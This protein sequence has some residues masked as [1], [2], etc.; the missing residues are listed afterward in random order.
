MMLMVQALQHVLL[1]WDQDALPSLPQRVIRDKVIIVLFQALFRTLRLQNANGSWG[2]TNSSEESA[3]AVIL[4][5]CLADLPCAQ[6]LW[7][8]V[9]C[10]I[11][12]GRSFIVQTKHDTA[13]SEYLWIEKV[14]YGSD[15]LRQAYIFAA[16]KDNVSGT[17][18]VMGK[19][20]SM[21]D[22]PTEKISKFMS[23]YSK[24]PM[25][26]DMPSWFVRGALVEGYLLL[27]QL[28]EVR[29][30]VF[31]RQGMAEDRY[32]EYIPFTWAA[33]NGIDKSYLGTDFIYQ[34]NVISFLNYQIDEYMEAVIGE[35]F[36][37]RLN[38]IRIIIDEIFHRWNTG[39]NG[40]ISNKAEEVDG[41]RGI[42]STKM[43]AEAIGSSHPNQSTTVAEDITKRFIIEV[44]G[45]PGKIS[46]VEGVD[47]QMDFERP[48][49]LSTNTS[50][51]IA[52]SETYETSASSVSSSSSSPLTLESVNV[53]LSSFVSHILSHT[54]IR[55][56]SSASLQD[57]AL[58]LRTFL[59]AHLT[60]IETSRRLYLSPSKSSRLN[61]ASTP[62]MAF[63]T[64][65]RSI[66]ADHTSCSYSFA[67]A[68]CLL[69]SSCNQTEGKSLD[70]FPTATSRYLAKATAQHL[71]S[72]CRMYNDFG[73][74][75]RDRAERNLNSVDFPE[76]KDHE[77]GSDG[78][79]GDAELKAR[80]M[81]LAEL[82]REFL[83]CAKR[84]LEREVDTI[85]G[86]H[87]NSN[88]DLAKRFV[89]CF[90]RITDCYGQIY[91]VK[92]IASR[93]K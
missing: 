56:A 35:Q 76:L 60:Q 44:Y 43:N 1:L 89:D 70:L 2:G 72:L 33:A 37:D 19:A 46:T 16:L 83:S 55:Y 53:T 63:F 61:H 84:R 18:A 26:Q 75:N 79:P 7:S 27:P 5:S 10:A 73:S 29:L 34:M 15:I 30:G 14:T 59:L 8:D 66:G 58:E 40:R 3:Y 23:F 12:K 90:V 49:T 54:E 82:E 68:S 65:A 31:S 64:W 36:A 6:I 24:L 80:L 91:V 21:F 25:F 86:M 81:K 42:H 22:L 11:E 39:T 17:K 9:E 38:E 57:L 85:G 77:Y 62:P 92:D 28:Q 74:L 78:V 93:M 32:F 48:Q 87:G 88:R 69:S 71:A 52:P 13:A 50:S 41:L 47:N 45:P 4:L 67:F 20:L 51:S